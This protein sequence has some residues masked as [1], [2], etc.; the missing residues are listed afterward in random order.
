MKKPVEPDFQWIRPD[1]KPTQYFL[2]LIQD[3]HARTHTMSVS[4]TEPANGEVLIYN[5]TTRQYEPGA[6]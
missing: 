4:K 1:G 3:M 2:E 5:S 6:N